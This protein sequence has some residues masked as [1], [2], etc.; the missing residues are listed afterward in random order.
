MLCERTYVRLEVHICGLGELLVCSS[1]Q[2]GL[3]YIA[4]PSTLYG[5]R[6]IRPEVCFGGLGEPVARRTA[7]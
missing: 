3:Y 5:R 2:N 4:Q 6:Y 1:E 7:G